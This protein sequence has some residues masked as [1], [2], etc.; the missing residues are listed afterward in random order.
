MEAQR[1]ILL[2]SFA[3]AGTS[4]DFL[5]QPSL[6]MRLESGKFE[7]S[8]ALHRVGRSGEGNALDATMQLPC[9]ETTGAVDP[10]AL[11]KI[12]IRIGRR[13]LAP[14]GTA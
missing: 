12:G 13:V 5:H 7:G 3:I 11:S 2:W 14:V 10:S 4:P 9:V 1:R 6:I 8:S